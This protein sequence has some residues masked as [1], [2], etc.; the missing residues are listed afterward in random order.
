MRRCIGL[1]FLAASASAPA[2]EVFATSTDGKLGARVD[3]IS[4][5]MTLPK[6][7]VSGL[8]NRLY[9]RVSLL[10]AGKIVG[11]RAVEIAIR[12]DLWEQ[13]FSV[14]STLDG[15]AVESR[16]FASRA[17]ID[18]MLGALPL[19]RLFDTATLPATRELVMRVELLLNPIGREKMRM[20]RKWVAQNSTPEVG[21]DQGISMSNTLFNRIF[22]QYTDGSDIA[23][24]W[25]VAAESKPFRLDNL[26]NERR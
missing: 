8:T 4:F 12:Y 3:A 26:A 15:A 19:P 25:R 1:L 5:P 23:A 24:V 2:A 11:R 22:E 7:L 14:V 21:G 9:A 20:L 18:A 17:D 13:K 16:S 10:D 6:E